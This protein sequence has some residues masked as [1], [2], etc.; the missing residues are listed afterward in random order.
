M[1]PALIVFL[2]SLYT[3]SIQPMD[4]YTEYIKLCGGG[5]RERERKCKSQK[6]LG[7]GSVREGGGARNG[8][9]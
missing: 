3:E 5:D 8:V 7:D 1:C 6:L 2:H 9:Y 4:A